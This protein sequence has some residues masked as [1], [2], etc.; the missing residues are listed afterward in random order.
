M[1]NESKHRATCSTIKKIARIYKEA[2]SSKETMAE[3]L[4][5]IGYDY[6]TVVKVS[7]NMDYYKPEV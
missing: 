2:G 5:E 6:V 1:T 4:F 3:E 7:L